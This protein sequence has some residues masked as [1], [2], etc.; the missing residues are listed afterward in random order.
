MSNHLAVP[1]NWAV[2]NNG[3]CIGCSKYLIKLYSEYVDGDMII[4]YSCTDYNNDCHHL[5]VNTRY[6]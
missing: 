5:C 6:N 4:V 1:I 3:H 2:Y